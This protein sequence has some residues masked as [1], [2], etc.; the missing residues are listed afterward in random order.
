VS[1]I[2]RLL[3]LF[4]VASA[5]TFLSG[6]G[7]GDSD[8]TNPG[9]GNPTPSISIN[10]SGTSLN[11]TAGSSG[12]I[13]VSVTRSGGFTGAVTVAADVPTGVTA[14]PVTVPAGSTSGVLTFQVAGTAAAGTVTATVRATGQGVQQVTAPVSLVIA[15]APAQDFSVA[16]GQSSA[17]LAQGGSVTVPV[18]ITRTNF[19]GAVTLTASGLPQGVTAAFDPAAP[20]GNSSTL[21]LTAGAAAATG[22]VNVTVQG[23]SGTLNRTAPLALTV[24][25]PAPSGDYTLTLNPTSV[26]FQQGGQATT[27]VN[28]NRTGGFNGT[29][30]LA[31]TGLPQGVTAAFNPASTDGNS[32]T[33]TL[34]AGAGATTGAATITVQGTATGIAA[35]TATLGVTVNPGGGGGSGNVS[36]AF[37]DNVGIPTWLAVQDGNGPWTRV[38]GDAQNVYRFQINSERAG[39]AW[40]DADANSTELQILYY[41]RAELLLIGPDQCGGTGG[42]K[43]VNGSVP[44]LAPTQAAFVTLGG[45]S[46]QLIGSQGQTA[47]T[48]NDVVDGPQ[49]LVAT[50]TNFNLQA[51]GLLPD[52]M[53][54]RRNLN[55]ANGSTLPPLDFAGEGFDPVTANGTINGLAAGE[56]SIVTGLFSTERGGLGTSY[57]GILGGANITWWGV[58]TARLESGDLHYLQVS[59]VNTTNPPV[60]IPPNTRQVGLGLREVT[61]FTTTLGP[62]YAVPTISTVATAPYVRLRATWTIQSEY[63]RSVF[64]SLAQAAALDSRFTSIILSDGYLNGTTTGDVAMPDFTGVDGWNNAW[65][66]V[67]GQEVTWTLGGSGW[68]GPGVVNFPDLAN[69]TQFFSA[70][71]SGLVTP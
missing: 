30:T 27:S 59:A 25:A 46:A 39:I 15:A 11:I 26:Q 67:A 5:A 65:G 1:S 23:A 54:I 64:V 57:A 3:G 36:F 38:T 52:R 69:G 6:C 71:T 63:N 53:I 44:G 55:P 41:S 22:A 19:T 18:Q 62:A 61:N 32:A 40:V 70:T 13:T 4:V 50:R 42:F 14:T 2:R 48:L 17:T 10:L 33:L 20:T 8:P 34:T 16:L 51:L 7:G 9:G 29:V 21:T 47:F 43:T 24:Q 66:L 12:Q 58:P 28:I 49:D 68:Q 35:R 60:G 45:A 31:A 56:Q 37:C